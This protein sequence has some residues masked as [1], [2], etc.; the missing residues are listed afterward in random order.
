MLRNL[1]LVV[2]Y[3]DIFSTKDESL[4]QTDVVQLEIKTEGEP[5]KMLITGY[6]QV[7]KMKPYRRK[8]EWNNLE[9]GIE[10]RVK[11]GLH[12]KSVHLAS[13]GERSKGQ[14]SG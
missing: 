7:L 6:L 1:E 4:E 8:K 11:K 5:I 3:R 14:A 13:P 12:S 2:E 10:I 9:S